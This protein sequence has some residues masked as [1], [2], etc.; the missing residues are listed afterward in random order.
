MANAYDFF[1][2]T[3]QENVCSEMT[4]GCLGF[5]GWALLVMSEQKCN[6]NGVTCVS[7]NNISVGVV[8]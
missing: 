8:G 2:T 7:N 3:I 1:Y 4:T 5:M 6:F